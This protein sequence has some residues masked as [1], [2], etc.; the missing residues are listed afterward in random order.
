MWG[1]EELGVGVVGVA[2]YGSLC[3]GDMWGESGRVGASGEEVGVFR[4]W[5]DV[6]VLGGGWTRESGIG[7]YNLQSPP[8][9]V[10][11]QP[12]AGCIRLLPSL[13][14]SSFAISAST[15]SNHGLLGLPIGLLPSTSGCCCYR[16]TPPACS[17]GGV[18]QLSFSREALPGVS[19]T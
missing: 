2:T 10:A 1:C 7:G 8:P 17:C 3:D 14:I 4:G 15:L 9:T 16:P 13:A 11:H 6:G 5:I 12:R 19:S 18:R